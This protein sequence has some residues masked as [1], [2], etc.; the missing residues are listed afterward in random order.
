MGG[1][2]GTGCTLRVHKCTLRVLR[3]HTLHGVHAQ[4]AWGAH[5][6]H[7]VHAQCVGSTLRVHGCTLRVHG[8]HTL[9]GVHAQGAW[10]A[11]SAQCAHSEC[12]D[13]HSGCMKSTL[14]V[15]GEHSQHT[16]C[17]LRL[18]FLSLGGLLPGCAPPGHVGAPGAPHISPRSPLS[19]GAA[20]SQAGDSPRAQHHTS[21]GSATNKTLFERCPAHTPG[22]AVL[23]KPGRA[24]WSWCHVGSSALEG[25]N[26]GAQARSG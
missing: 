24:L 4:G 6:V 12:M 5:S 7:R 22:E 15:H 21:V 20:C 18:H 2:L 14:R 23:E 17:M 9:H 1:T 13:A 16:G 11:R 19:S 8:V 25:R 3:V 26:C 10:G